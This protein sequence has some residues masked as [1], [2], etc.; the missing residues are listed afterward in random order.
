MSIVD[1]PQLTLK[2][3]TSNFKFRNF[4]YFV[5]EITIP[6]KRPTTNRSSYFILTEKNSQ[7]LL[8]EKMGLSQKEFHEIRSVYG[9]K[10]S[11]LLEIMQLSKYQFIF[12]G[13]VPGQCEPCHHL[14]L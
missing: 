7:K 9:V 2:F 8:M 14:G 3:Q 1:C 6:M 4:D 12:T 13:K 5:C 10:A 11:Q